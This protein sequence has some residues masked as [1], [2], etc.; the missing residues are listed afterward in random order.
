LIDVTSGLRLP[1]H[2]PGFVVNQQ[3]FILLITAFNGYVDFPTKKITE[4]LA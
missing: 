3:C 2:W 1:S 4:K